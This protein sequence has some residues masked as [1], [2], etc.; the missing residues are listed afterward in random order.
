MRE[1]LIIFES[2]ETLSTLLAHMAKQ[3]RSCVNCITSYHQAVAAL[4]E[5][6]EQEKRY[7]MRSMEIFFDNLLQQDIVRC[8]HNTIHHLVHGMH[9]PQR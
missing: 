5:Q 2:K 7:T 4:R 9:V 3:L 1:L 6:F 8:V